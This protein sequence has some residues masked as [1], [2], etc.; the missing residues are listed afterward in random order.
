MPF[1]TQPF[2]PPATLACGVGFGG[3]G[4]AGVQFILEILE[5]AKMFFRVGAG[6]LIKESL[7]L[8]LQHSHYVA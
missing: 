3:A 8:I 1:F 7:N 5:K 4:G 6:L 2:T